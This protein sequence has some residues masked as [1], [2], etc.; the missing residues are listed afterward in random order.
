MTAGDLGYGTFSNHVPHKMSHRFHSLSDG[1]CGRC[2]FDFENVIL[3]ALQSSPWRH[4]ERDGISN[5]QR[6]DSSLNR[7]FITGEFP[8]QSASNADFV[9]IWCRHYAIAFFGICCGIAFSVNGVGH[10]HDTSI[11]FQVMTWCRQATGHCPNQFWLRSMASYGV[12]RSQWSHFSLIQFGQV[13]YRIPFV[14]D[15]YDCSNV[16]TLEDMCE[17]DW[18][19]AKPQQISGKPPF[20]YSLSGT[21]HIL[22]KCWYPSKLNQ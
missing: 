3:N 1:G 5:H 10:Y 14:M 20:V 22:Q 8:A 2:G 15:A 11:L 18:T 19:D 4:N 17:I 13:I 12:S 21:M 16:L 9:F 7:L 6:L